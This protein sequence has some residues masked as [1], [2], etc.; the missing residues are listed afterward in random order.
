[1]HSMHKNTKRYALLGAIAVLIGFAVWFQ[2]ILNH[3]HDSLLQE[4]IASVSHDVDFVCDT[5]DYLVERDEG[6]DIEKY[7]EVLVF[8]V[9]KMD[10]AADSRLYAELFDEQLNS[11]STRSPLFAGSPFDPREVP[12]L[13]AVLQSEESGYFLTEHTVQGKAHDMHIQ[14]RWIPTGDHHNRV[15]LVVGVTKYAINTEIAVWV[16]WSVVAIMFVTAIFIVGSMM[17]LTVEKRRH[18]CKQGCQF[19][20]KNNT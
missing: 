10:A 20:A 13:F 1:M 19:A 6:W 16:S 4:R 3:M 15:L 9:S 18:R 8:L 7:Q 5:L 2:M 14:F 12:D 11:I 17:A